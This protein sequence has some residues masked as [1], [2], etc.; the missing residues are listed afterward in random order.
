[1]LLDFLLADLLLALDLLLSGL[2]GRAGPLNS[3]GQGGLF[4]GL[5]STLLGRLDVNLPVSVLVS[6]Q[7]ALLGL[8]SKMLNLNGFSIIDDSGVGSLQLNDA[9]SSSVDSVVDLSI[10]G[11]DFSLLSGLQRDHLAINLNFKLFSGLG[12]GVGRLHS[13]LGFLD[14]DHEVLLS[15]FN[16]SKDR[17]SVLLSTVS[18]EDSPAVIKLVSVGLVVIG[19]NNFITNGALLI[20]RL[21]NER[22]NEFLTRS[23]RGSQGNNFSQLLRKA[24]VSVLNSFIL[25]GQ[26]HIN[27]V[28]MGLELELNLSFISSSSAFNL[29]HEGNKSSLDSSVKKPD[30]VPNIIGHGGVFN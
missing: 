25:G 13:D 2:Q 6:T 10:S 14:K 20:D 29:G 7:A 17:V 28:H 24:N 5:G 11:F 16:L 9:V 30:V 3:V 23:V 21:A 8:G 27:S 22:S 1:L 26:S 19:F 4:V 18:R 15:I 12:V